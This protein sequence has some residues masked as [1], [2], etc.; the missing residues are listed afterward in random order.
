M[1]VVLPNIVSVDDLVHGNIPDVLWR[2]WRIPGHLY[3]LWRLW[4]YLSDMWR[5][6]RPCAHGSLFKHF[7]PGAIFDGYCSHS[8]A[9]GDVFFQVLQQAWLV[10]HSR[11]KCVFTCTR[12]LYR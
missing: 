8:E 10:H 9:V 4:N 5:L 1:L 3:W 11:Q 12:A 6:E 7:T 2:R